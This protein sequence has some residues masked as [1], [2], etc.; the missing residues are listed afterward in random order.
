MA[1]T[2]KDHIRSVWR[3]AKRQGIPGA[4]FLGV[5]MAAIG[6]YYDA[7]ALTLAGAVV[8]GIAGLSGAV[9]QSEFQDTIETQNKALLDQAQRLA[10]SVTGGLS[11]CHAYPMNE[12]SA[13]NSFEWLFIHAGPDPIYEVGVRI[14][15]LERRSNAVSEL[16]GRTYK[17]G[18]LLP[19]KAQSF[20]IVWQGVDRVACN[21]FFTARNG[22]WTQEFRRIRVPDGWAYINRVGRWTDKPDDKLALY[23]VSKNFPRKADGSIDWGDLPPIEMEQGS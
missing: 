16:I 15:N 19:G 23:D 18:T 6:A 3:F 21:L 2:G 8:S 4:A 1:S 20:S 12:N 14:V 11:F 5:G 7:G 9:Q 13:A 17:L 10:A 22:D